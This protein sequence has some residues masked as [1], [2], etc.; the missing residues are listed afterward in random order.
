MAAGC[1][2]VASGLAEIAMAQSDA[3]QRPGPPPESA[4]WI[5]YALGIVLVFVVGVAAF[6]SSKRGH[7][8]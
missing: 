7:Q 2:A 6:K 4:P 1:A 5:A 8:D 3:P